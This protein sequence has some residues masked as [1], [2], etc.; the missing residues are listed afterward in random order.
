MDSVPSNVVRHIRKL[1][2]AYG[3]VSDL[4]T[5]YVAANERGYYDSE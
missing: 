4:A 2:D 5:P 3:E 1:R